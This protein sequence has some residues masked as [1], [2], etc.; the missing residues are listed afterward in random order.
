MSDAQDRKDAE[1]EK[2]AEDAG[3]EAV[4]KAW[5]A[6]HYSPYDGLIHKVWGDNSQRQFTDGESTLEDD[7]SGVNNHIQYRHPSRKHHKQHAHHGHKHFGQKEDK[8]NAESSAPSVDELPT[9]GNK[10]KTKSDKPA[11]VAEDVPVKE[12]EKEDEPGPKVPKPPPAKPVAA[13]DA[14]PETDTTAEEKPKKSFLRDDTD[15]PLPK[16]WVWKDT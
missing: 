12:V 9:A 10:P 6:A 7:V 16:P 14:V 15:K 4:K 1:D 8:P 2:K 13:K 3:K 11:G 5:Y